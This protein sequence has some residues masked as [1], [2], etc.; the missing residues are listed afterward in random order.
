MPAVACK[1]YNIITN[2]HSWSRALSHKH[3]APKRLTRMITLL[4]ESITNILQT[5]INCQT[6][7]SSWTEAVIKPIPKVSNPITLKDFRPISLLQHLS[8]IAERIFL[9]HLCSDIT[10]KL[11]P[12]QFAYSPGLTT[13]DALVEKIDQWTRV[14]DKANTICISIALKDFTKAFDKMQH[15]KLIRKMIK[16]NAKPNNIAL[17]QSF[18]SGRK[19]QVAVNNTISESAESP[20]GVP[21]GT[22]TGPV[23]WLIF[24]DDL[25]PPT[26]TVKYADDTTSFITITTS[27]ITNR[28][29]TRQTFSLKPKHQGI[30]HGNMPFTTVRTGVT[31]MTCS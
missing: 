27:C 7:P 2:L 28:Q 30:Q 31:K 6:F 19:Q 13:T 11:Q 22:V 10:N 21:Q 29:S 5:V 8:K 24:V 25:Q 4:C 26:P 15:A 3:L 1:Q 12:N 23:Y 20:V 16:R 18:L 9:E 17:T 14:L